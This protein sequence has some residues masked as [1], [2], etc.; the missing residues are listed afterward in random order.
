ME[1]QKHNVEQIVKEYHYVK[2]PLEKMLRLIEILKHFSE[3]NIFDH[4]CLKGGTA[5]NLLY[6]PLP[7]LSVDIDLDITDNVSGNEL[8]ELKK[9]LNNRITEYMVSAGYSIHPASKTHY[10]LTSF[11]F[12]YETLWN[13]NDVLKIEI[14]NMNRCHLYNTVE[15]EVCVPWNSEKITVKTLSAEELF[16]SKINALIDRGTARDLYD[17]D[18]LSKS[19]LYHSIDKERLHKAYLFY[20]SVGTKEPYYPIN[21]ENIDKIN[22]NKFKRETFSLLKNVTHFDI[23]QMKQ[24][25]SEVIFPIISANER[26][27]EYL[28]LFENG[29]YKPELLF[30][31]PDVVNRIQNHPMAQWKMQNINKSKTLNE[32][33][34]TAEGQQK[35]KT[36]KINRKIKRDLER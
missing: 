6:L 17:I 31:D 24:N 12:N 4:L 22:I 21:T 16:A 9:Y 23:N 11:V 2:A 28:R 20:H 5:I 27:Q 32:K 14:S 35:R 30:D 3:E 34:E 7:R 33:L 13:S 15:K 10:A 26:E 25:V 1:L 36:T 19:D 29:I 18:S 8:Q